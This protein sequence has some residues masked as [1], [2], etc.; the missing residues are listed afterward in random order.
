MSDPLGWELGAT[1]DSV[2]ISTEDHPG[3]STKPECQ[4][5]LVVTESLL[6]TKMVESIGGDTCKQSFVG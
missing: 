6:S 3:F 5:F 2:L 4:A 1:L